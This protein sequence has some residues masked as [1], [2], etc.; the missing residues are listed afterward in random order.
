MQYENIKSPNLIQI[1]AKT[2]ATYLTFIMRLISSL[3]NEK[4][5]NL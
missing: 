1:D 3:E 4:H 5:A 2:L